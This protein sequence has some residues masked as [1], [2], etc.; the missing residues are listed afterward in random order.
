MP[1]AASVWLDVMPSM[2]EFRRELRR[3]LEDP[4]AQ[5]SARAGAQGGEGL[6]AGMKGKVLAGAAAVGVAAGALLTKGIE[7]AVAKQKATGMLKAQLDLSAAEAQ[8]A[9]KAAGKLYAGTVTETIADGAAAVKAIMASGLA[10][11]KATTKQ[12]AAIATKAQDLTTLF[13]IDLAQ[14]A[15]AAGQMVKTGLAKNATE[16][17]DILTRGFQTM[18]P[19]AD[20]LADTFNE[21]STIFRSLGL[22][23]KVSMGLFSQGMQ[24]GARDT[25]VVADALKEFQ[26]RTT[27]GSK[28]SAEGFKLLG[29]SAKDSTAMFAKG[30][31]GAAKGLQT[32]LD[33]LRAMPDRVDRNA[34]AVALFGTKAEDLGDALF[35]LDPSKAVGDLGKVGGA[36]KRAGD[37]LRDNAGAKFEAFKRRGLM[38]L[39]DVTAKYV[40]PRIEDFI[41]FIDREAVPAVQTISAGFMSGVRWVKEYGVWFAPLAIAIGGV[42][43]AMT[44]SSIAT[45]ITIGVLSV[46]SIAIRTAAAVTR[47]WTLV[48]AGF[49]A[50][51][52]LNPVTLIVIGVLAL[53]AAVVVAYKK[54]ETFRTIVQGAWAGIKAG[55]DAVWNRGLKPGFAG[56]MVGL[57]A[58]GAAGMWLWNNA[59][60]P[61]FSAIDTGAR[62]MATIIGVVLVVPAVLA[63]RQLGSVGK[64][65]WSNAIGPAFRAIGAGAVWLWKTAI[66]PQLQSF[67]AGL[68]AVGAAGKWLWTNALKPAFNW[69]VGGAVSLWAGVK[70]QAGHIMTGLRAL[71]A[72]GTWLWKNAIKPAF[73]NIGKGASWLYQQGIKPPIDKAKSLAKSLGEAF[74]TGADAV[75]KAFTSIKE[76]AKKPIEFVIDTVYNKGI[77]GVWN[78]VAA[79]FGAP[80]LDRF[81][82][83][84]RGGVLAG[85]SSYRQGDD[86][87]VPLRRGE[88]IAVS[89]AMRD[90]YERARLLAVNDA[91]MHGRSLRAFQGGGF[92]RG[93]IFDWVKGAASK[94]VDLAK[95]G[96]GWLKDGVRAS[97]VAGLDAVVKPLIAK[98]SGSASLYRDMVT[99]IPKKMIESIIGYSGRAD[100]ALEKA[101]IGGKGFK[102]ALTWARAQAGK[103]YIWGGVGPQGF[104]CSGFLSAIENMIRGLAPNRRRWATGAFSGATA[105]SGWVLNARSPFQIG[106][107]NAGVG[108]T[109]GTLQGVNV[110]SRGGDGVVVGSR[111][112]SANAAMF[113]HRYGLR[114]FASG[115]RPRPGELAWVGEQGPELVRFGGGDTEVYDTTTSM[116]M[117]SALGRLRGFAKGTTSAAK[118]AAARRAAAVRAAATRRGQVKARAA[119]GGDLAA[120]SKSLTGSAADIGK[121][122]AKLARDLAA[123]GGAGVRLSKVVKATTVRLQ[124]LATKRN[125]VS[126]RIAEA[127]GFANDKS[128][129]MSDFLGI[130]ALGD[131]TSVGGLIAGMKG[132]QAT[133]KNFTASLTTLAKRGASKELIDQLDALGPDSQLAGL[134]SRASSADIKQINALVKSGGALSTSYGRTMADLMY[135]AGK[136]SAKGFLTGL[137]AE[138]KAIQDAMAQLGAGAIKAIRGKK[139][140]DARSPSRKGKAAGADLG[141]G[142]VAGMAAMGPQVASAAERLGQAAVPGGLVPVTSHRAGAD[143]VAA[144]DGAAIALVLDDGTRLAA[145]FE[146]RID[147]RL[148]TARR[149]ARAGTKRK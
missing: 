77:R 122:S 133:A 87:L 33:K 149:T 50:V 41:E 147:A 97:A 56:F 37:D 120:F 84:A 138:E 22:D 74:K 19:R 10:P 104:D 106:I 48:Q 75:G 21:Y 130:A 111:A 8:K 129:V 93:G 58:V 2:A 16:A 18:G 3:N 107:T 136:G 67:M 91:A 62:I 102:S 73:D 78:E 57:R 64:W 79:K 13:E 55:W 66:R 54:S 112:R 72:V 6:M 23:A 131:V 63:F 98:I 128:K 47:A 17:F 100:T 141:A 24:A 116:R 94:G 28:A 117:A 124:A 61:V 144:L 70:T 4:V 132:K 35:A 109:A 44:A 142:V 81:P 85:Q 140:I 114:G 15:N 11:E 46:Y 80:T 14:G 9:G 127:K 53:A 1:R 115:G 135:D 145:H 12:L 99:R 30:G 83:F 134:V 143:P 51:M 95:A 31:A 76:K 38:L 113:T 45:G 5:A 119:I 52:A 92:A 88:G 49:N 148:S 82:G 146:S 105:P 101:G 65:L 137:L 68:R 27:D 123:A 121:A 60:K 69:I 103:P 71:G 89:E 20:D 26:I 39:G 139:G 32:V 7:E 126:A 29:M 110:E 96:V 43:L 42:T 118:M 34:A 59:L 40:L 25:D 90:P 86:Q 108:H 36:A 125:K